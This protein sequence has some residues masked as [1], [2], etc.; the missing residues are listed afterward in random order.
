MKY[1]KSFDLKKLDL[2]IEKTN[3]SFLVLFVQDIVT[4]KDNNTHVFNKGCVNQH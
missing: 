4:K 2:E 1:A 3:F